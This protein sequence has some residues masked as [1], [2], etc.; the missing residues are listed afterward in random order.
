MKVHRQKNLSLFV[1]IFFLANSF[2]LPVAKADPPAP[3]VAVPVFCLRITDIALDGGDAEAD[4]FII[5]FEIVNWSATEAFEFYMARNI[6][7]TVGPGAPFI[8]AAS[9]D[10]D[11]RPIGVGSDDDNFPPAD[12]T[13]LPAKVGA[14]NTWGAAFTATTATYTEPTSVG[15]AGL[16]ARDLLGAASDA[17]ACALVPGCVLVPPPTV[18]DFETVDNAIGPDNVLDGFVIEIDDFDAGD[19]ISLNWFL[20][21]SAGAFI[22]VSGLGNDFGFGA[23]NIFRVA[24]SGPALFIRPSTAPEGAGSNVGTDSSTK[25]MFVSTTTGGESFEIEVGVAITPTFDTP[26]DNKFTAPIN[27]TLIVP[28]PALSKWGL[29]LFLLLS[30]ATLLVVRRRRSRKSTV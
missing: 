15:G 20:A 18:A 1:L 6:G 17:A 13:G 21:D 3:S 2:G 30:T 22:G 24:S 10:G 26:A 14:A 5:E 16:A 11:G 25:N 29:L 8:A 23:I 4:R 27:A 12:G 19:M 7:G 28:I 9:I